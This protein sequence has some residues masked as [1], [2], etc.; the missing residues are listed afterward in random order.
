MLFR[1]ALNIELE[2]YD[3][4]D[5]KV[6]EGILVGKRYQTIWSPGDHVPPG[7]YILNLRRGTEFQ[8]IRVIKTL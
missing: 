1:S 7:M 3:L 2:L 8:R 6:A 5:R 4:M